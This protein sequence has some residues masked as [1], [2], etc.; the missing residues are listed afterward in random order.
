MNK[1]KI[2]LVDDE[3]GFTTILKLSLPA[4]DVCAVDNPLH[5]VETARRFRPDLIF[6]DVIMPECDGGTIA[7]EFKQDPA[8]RHIPI[9]FLTAIVS[10]REASMKHD[11]GGYEFL[12]KPVGR[13][14]VIEC[15]EKHLGPC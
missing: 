11:I 10:K 14:Q 1:K 15:V 5:A 4:F 3:P 7:A 6:L 12:A 9:I 13:D 2:L 8:L